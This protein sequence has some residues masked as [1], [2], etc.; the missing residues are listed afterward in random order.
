MKTQISHDMR[1]ELIGHPRSFKDNFYAKIILAHSWT[2]FDKN[3][4][5]EFANITIFSINYKS[6]D[7]FGEFLT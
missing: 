5:E 7:L 2:D 4:K 3:F 6:R 1:Y